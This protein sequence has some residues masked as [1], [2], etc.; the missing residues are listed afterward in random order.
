MKNKTQVTKEEFEKFIS[1]YPNTL[2][3]D[4]AH[5][6]E[7]PIKTW[8]DFTMANKWPDSVVAYCELYDGSDYHGG[9]QPEYFIFEKYYNQK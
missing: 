2:Q 1:T 9:M 3:T 7:P 4:V 6:F 5:F 8:N